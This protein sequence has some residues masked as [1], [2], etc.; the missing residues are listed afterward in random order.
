MKGGASGLQ[1]GFPFDKLFQK[2]VL[3]VEYG[4]GEIVYPVAEDKDAG[5]GT[6]HQIQ[7]DVPMTVDEEVYIRMVLQILFGIQYKMLV[8]FAHVVGLFPV[9]SFQAAVLCPPQSEL[10]AP[11]GVEEKMLRDEYET[12]FV[13]NKVVFEESLYAKTEPLAAAARKV[14]SQIAMVGWTGSG[15][16]AGYVPVFAIGAGSDLF[17]GKMD[18]TEIPKRIAKAAG[19]K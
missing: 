17:V 10:Y 11:A 1:F 5:G 2:Q 4:I 19:Y 15:H 18:N 8:V 13:K 3:A 9:Y 7:F 6:Q 14:M 16:T 12:S